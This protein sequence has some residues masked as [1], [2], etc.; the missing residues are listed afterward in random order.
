MW[1]LIKNKSNQEL[2]DQWV[3]DSKEW[4]EKKLDKATEN[5]INDQVEK[6]F[7]KFL[8]EN[9][10]TLEKLTDQE[11]QKWFNDWIDWDVSRILDSWKI[12]E[13]KCVNWDI[14]KSL[15]GLT[16][17][18]ELIELENTIHTQRE[19]E[20]TQT[21]LSSGI[22]IEWIISN[23]VDHK[24]LDTLVNTINT[25]NFTEKD[26]IVD[27]L[28][29]WKKEDI[30]KIQ[31]LLIWKKWEYQNWK[32]WNKEWCLSKYWTDWL[33]WSETYKALVDY[34]NSNKITTAATSPANT[35]TVGSTNNP[36]NSP[37]NN[38]SGTTNIPINTPSGD[39]WN[40]GNPW[41][42]PETS[43]D[44]PLDAWDKLHNVKK[45][46]E[47]KWGEVVTIATGLSWV[48]VVPTVLKKQFNFETDENGNIVYTLPNEDWE[49]TVSIKVWDKVRTITIKSTE[50]KEWP[51]QHNDLLAEIDKLDLERTTQENR[52]I[53][54]QKLKELKIEHNKIK[55]GEKVVDDPEKELKAIE[56]SAKKL[57]VAKEKNKLEEYLNQ[58]KK[59][60]IEW[61]NSLNNMI[62]DD[63][64][65]YIGG[66]YL[67]KEKFL[68][69]V[70][71]KKADFIKEAKYKDL[72]VS[73]PDN[74][75]NTD[76]NVCKI[77]KVVITDDK[78]ILN[79][80]KIW[81]EEIQYDAYWYVEMEDNE[82]DGTEKRAIKKLVRGIDKSLSIVDADY[83]KWPA[84]KNN[85]N[86]LRSGL[87][88][89]INFEPNNSEWGSEED[90]IKK[91]F[92][93]LA[94]KY[95]D[96]FKWSQ[97]DRKNLIKNEFH[98][99][100]DIQAW[101]MAKLWELYV[102][103]KN[104]QDSKSM[105][106]YFMKVMWLLE[107]YFMRWVKGRK[108]DVSTFKGMYIEERIGKANVDLIDSDKQNKAINQ[109]FKKPWKNSK[110]L[111]W[112]SFNNTK[113][114]N[115]LKS[116]VKHIDLASFFARPWIAQGSDTTPELRNNQ[117]RKFYA[118]YKK[119]IT[120]LNNN[121]LDGNWKPKVLDDEYY[122]AVFDF[123][124]WVWESR[125]DIVSAI[126]SLKL[127]DGE[128][129]DDVLKE[130]GFKSVDEMKLVCMLCD[131]N[132]DWRLD[133]GDK[134]YLMWLE[135]KNTYKDAMV[136]H[137]YWVTKK[138]PIQNLMEYAKVYA[139]KSWSV[140]MVKRLGEI[141]KK[142]RASI[143]EIKKDDKV[144]S[145]EVYDYE[146]LFEDFQNDPSILK[147]LQSLL[148]NSPVDMVDNIFKYWAG[149]EVKTEEE[150]R[151]EQAEMTASQEAIEQI[152]ND[153]KFNEAF[154]REWK[155]LTEQWV[156]DTPEVKA[157][158]KPVVAAWVVANT[159]QTEY[160][161]QD[162]N[163][164]H[165]DKSTSLSPK[166]AI[167]GVLQTEK[168][169]DFSL[170]LWAWT[171][172]DKWSFDL[173]SLW[174]CIWWWDSRRVWKEWN[175]I[176][177]ARVW[178][179]A[180]YTWQFIP[181]AS[182]GFEVSTL[183]NKNQLKWLSPKPAAYLDMWW[184]IW[185]SWEKTVFGEV[186]VWVS[187]DKLEWIDRTYNNIKEQLWWE[188]WLIA[189]VL[190]N[191]D[192][193]QDETEWW[194][195]I[196][197]ALR[198]RFFKGK[199]NLSK[200][201]MN[202]LDWATDNIYRWLL[203]YMVWTNLRDIKDE[204]QKK[205]II[206]W[207]ADNIAESYA[208]S[209][210]NKSLQNLDW[211]V[212]L[213]RFA[214][215]LIFLEWYYPFPMVWFSFSR[216]RWLCSTETQSSQKEYQRQLRTEWNAKQQWMDQDL[217]FY[218]EENEIMTQRWIE[219]INKK[220]EIANWKVEVPDIK[221]VG[222]VGVDGKSAFIQL[223]KDLYK[224]VNI[225]VD[226]KLKDYASNDNDW[227]VIVP[228]NTILTLLTSS[229]TNDGKFNLIIWDTKVDTDDIVIWAKND[230]LEWD[231]KSYQSYGW[232]RWE[233]ILD[234]NDFNTE[235]DDK[236]GKKSD[237]PIQKCE[238]TMN[239]SWETYAL[240]KLKEWKSIVDM[241]WA[242]SKTKVDQRSGTIYAP[243]TG[244]LT[245]YQTN[246]G[247]YQLYYQ[248]SP[249]NSMDIN[250][251]VEW[252][253]TTT[254]T[255]NSTEKTASV[256]F[257]TTEKLY[258]KSFIN[259]LNSVLNSVNNKDVHN[260]LL[261]YNT[262]DWNL[263]TQFMDATCNVK[264]DG[265]VDKTDYSDALSKLMKMLN[266]SSKFKN[267]YQWLDKLKTL[268]NRTD[269][270]Q[271]QTMMI[272]DQCK[273]FFSYEEKL[274]DWKWDAAN[275]KELI[276]NRGIA[277]EDLPGYVTTWEKFPLKWK[278]YRSKV[279]S[280]LE[281]RADLSSDVVW[282]L[283][284]M[285][286]FYKRWKWTNVQ[287]TEW[288]GYSMTEMWNTAPLWWVMVPIESSEL[289]ATKEWFWKNF[290]ASEVHKDILTQTILDHV[291]KLI[292]DNVSDINANDITTDHIDKILK[293][294]ESID[295]WWKNV[296]IDLNMNYVFYLLQE[297]GNESIWVQLSWIKI[298]TWWIEIEEHVNP[299]NPDNSDATVKTTRKWWFW[300]YTKTHV[301]G[302]G[303]SF[304]HKWSFGLWLFGGV[305]KT[306]EPKTEGGVH[307]NSENGSWNTQ[308]WVNWTWHGR[309]H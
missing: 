274:T 51:A 235:L 104:N 153:A 196:Q 15:R 182:L 22:T 157:R 165:T 287:L 146:S 21:T 122:N 250:Y 90:K 56:K 29:K 36:A 41:I 179:W 17:E 133:F 158:F 33:L 102:A 259:E 38:P 140:S 200:K 285:T 110:D 44:A 231:E 225:N 82:F 139:E 280:Q 88:A 71:T 301:A 86:R 63:A 131:L 40:H 129:E 142:N 190:N 45:L 292:S 293:W 103:Y 78:N 206:K 218:D 13:I 85:L 219:Y 212:N 161:D 42:N 148:V 227:N 220:L 262:N 152:M 128:I 46:Y 87:I 109:L 135:I 208:T 216:Y 60:K 297:C 23:Q 192:F 53:I 194:N 92:T 193:W 141:L 226:P 20:S 66:V 244:T 265:R 172:V 77:T 204:K 289:A 241:W 147:Y 50:S 6:S 236:F 112:V 223:P 138:F 240:L 25:T 178:G 120:S 268:V 113:E 228:A 174:L 189:E 136:D 65:I 210:K 271:N 107:N 304:A 12:N 64:I 275:L 2:L 264:D 127:Y 11:K 183:V 26:Y 19:N 118:E 298:E 164:T 160:H 150:S 255:S 266:N 34:I 217:W 166:A 248:S 43:L 243:Q 108:G 67:T 306:T 154:E 123:L 308:W 186:H 272:V 116:I 238:K 207:I 58:A 5:K 156:K 27:C 68:Q 232:D 253:E 201:D 59:W 213:D 307:E 14:E 54:P 294:E 296:K 145:E 4:N 55:S 176:V 61:K 251:E 80:N 214:V 84:D 247:K 302:N 270:T 170:M 203:Y 171:S 258:W 173:Q 8:E 288:R 283:V 69:W 195:K 224:Y 96:N 284:G 309:T 81:N 246:D 137:E 278:N 277:Y 144:E 124:V 202:D 134:W 233:Y 89:L 119:Y 101:N 187:R 245:V 79:N 31:Y 3:F 105:W 267:D 72:D 121:D 32:A 57:L 276:K 76:S 151:I 95:R 98:I 125:W 167:G 130:S 91:V 290:D 74:F 230:G 30:R 73:I 249:H 111:L 221:L 239:I 295:I 177:S 49:W 242:N 175:T 1:D 7:Q 143:K 191:V 100:N 52:E 229:K 281:W 269:L 211:K 263:Y 162:G 155:K 261:E 37:A 114:L 75:W 117:E 254:Y 237:F 209:W 291:K 39:A 35:P 199:N 185:V 149:D 188:K 273:M 198:N 303:Q 16:F 28:N 299:A 70:R 159:V 180:S 24:M 215:W 197:W 205:E 93:F 132:A 99:K 300:I 181:F 286:A 9:K 18:V 168:A 222:S 48:D 47:W 279:V 83:K 257:D 260:L 94:D 234:V 106:D 256:N 252:K 169:W 97:K 305:N 282:N 62:I 126:N 115:N 10:T 163:L 184:S